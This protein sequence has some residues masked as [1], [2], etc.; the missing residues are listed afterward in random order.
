[1]TDLT[2]EPTTVDPNHLDDLVKRYTDV[3]AHVATLNAELDDIKAELRAA[4]TTTAPC[5]I[6]VTVTPNRRFSA[7]RAAEVLPPSLLAAVSRPSIDTSLA[8]EQLP[9][10]LYAQ[11]M[12][13]VGQPRVAVK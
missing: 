5:G 8:K 2:A 9:P 1:M 3:A 7:D 4:G 10:A 6:K 13:E 12:V 11:C